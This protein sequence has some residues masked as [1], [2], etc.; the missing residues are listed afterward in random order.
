MAVGEELDF[1]INVVDCVNDE[2]RTLAVQ[3]C[4]LRLCYIAAE[5]LVSAVKVRPWCYLF[6]S[7]TK[8]VYFG[9]TDISERSYCMS[10]QR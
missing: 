10:V 6:Q 4:E 1:R 7:S 2:G 8:G 9:C 5:E 3:R